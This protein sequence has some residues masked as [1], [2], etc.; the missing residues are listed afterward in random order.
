MKTA[1]RTAA[2]AVAALTL[3][4]AG[5]SGTAS[6]TSEPRSPQ[7]AAAGGAAGA[8]ANPDID[9]G[10]DTKQTEVAPTER[11]VARTAQ[12]SVKIPDPAVAAQRIRTLAEGLGGFVAAERVVTEQRDGYYLRASTVVVQVPSDRLD[13]ALDALAQVGTVTDRVVNSA[14][15]TTQV[16]DVEARIKTLRESIARIEQLMTKAGTVAEIAQVESELTSRQTQLESLLAQQKAL[17]ARVAMSPITITLN[18]DITVAEPNPLLQGLV[19][20]WEALLV[21][22]RWLITF[23]GAALPFVALALV[24]WLPVRAWLR[25]RTPR[26]RPAAEP[27]TSGGGSTDATGTTDATGPTDASKTAA[28]TPTDGGGSAG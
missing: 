9:L 7:T 15:V 11:Q 24:V 14:D 2:A 10:G 21:S 5:C 20:G 25:H 12:V 17:A 1:A 13:E 8:P 19:A 27:S 28:S 4:L 26:V 16:V 6:T 3:A 18:P 22:L 23:L